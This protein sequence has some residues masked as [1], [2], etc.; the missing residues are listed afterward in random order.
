MKPGDAVVLSLIH[1]SHGVNNAMGLKTAA[2][3]QLISHDPADRDASVLQRDRKRPGHIRD[4]GMKAALRQQG[5]GCLLYTS[6]T[7]STTPW[8]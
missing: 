7:A 1:I 2:L 6:H 8:D 4:M 3:W 5:G